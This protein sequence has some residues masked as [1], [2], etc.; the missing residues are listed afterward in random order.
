M[1]FFHVADLHLDSPFQGLASLPEESFKKIRQSTFQALDYLVKDALAKDVDAV[2]FAGDIYDQ[3]IQ[4]IEAQLAFYD[5]CKQLISAEI[6]VFICHGNHDYVAQGEIHTLTPQG[7]I[8]FGPEVETIYAESK[9]GERYAVTS[10]SY[11]SRWIGERR[12][13]EYPKRQINVDYHL[14][15]M[16]GNLESLTSPHGNYAP[17]SVSEVEALNYDYFA[18][19]HVHETMSLSDYAAIYYAGCIQGRHRLERGPKGYLDVTLSPQKHEVNFVE[20]GAF[21]FE[22]INLALDNPRRLNDLYE[23][24]FQELES[25]QQD[26]LVDLR[27]SFKDS[28]EKSIHEQLLT[29]AFLE[30]IQ[31]ESKAL[32]AHVY[33]IEVE[34]V[35]DIEKELAHHFVAEFEKAQEKV[36][37]K[38]YLKNLAEPLWGTYAKYFDNASWTEDFFSRGKE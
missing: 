8:A 5:A 14:G 17:F 33:N 18:L 22:E 26:T 1:R 29:P 37:S 6:Q 15:M 13:L 28:L 24:I 25:I 20:A 19:G 34:V 10:F 38:E 11:D 35:T 36:Y 2:L 3:N 27:L 7:A 23:D 32:F 4:S 21:R 30:W 12:I 31:K 9:E 16:H